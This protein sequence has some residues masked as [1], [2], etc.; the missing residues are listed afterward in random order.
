[1]TQG[2]YH[3]S[4]ASLSSAWETPVFPH[5]Y[6]EK[7]ADAVFA[8]RHTIVRAPTGAGKTLSVLAPFL[9]GRGKNC[10]QKL[11][12]VLPLRTLVEAIF[13]ESCK[14]AQ[15][16]GLSVA[17]Q[18]GER[19]DAEF[20][21]D[22]DI[23][24]TTFDQLLSGLLCEPYGLPRKLWNINAAAI[25]G[26]LIAFDEFH[27][28][29]PAEA[30]VTALFGVEMFKKMC[31]SVWMTATATAP[32]TQMIKARIG[33]S[34]IELS[35][36]EQI[37]LFEGR[38][39]SR[40]LRTHWDGTLTCDE[41]LSHGKSRVLAVVNT[42]GRAQQLAK[43]VRIATGNTPLLL[44]AR[45][46]SDDRQ[47]KQRLLKES[48]LTIATQVIEAGVDISCDVLLTEVAPVNALVQRAGRCA[49]FA[50]ESGIVHVYGTASP[51]PYAKSS[52]DTARSTVLD[53][54]QLDPHTCSRWVERAHAPED[55]D[56]LTGFG[57]LINKRRNLILGHVAGDGDLGAAAYIRKGAD[58]VR[59]FILKDATGA[60]PQELQ[61][62]QLYRNKVA[63]F[64]NSAHVYDGEN[65]IA[66]GDI[67]TAYAV[68]L[69][70]S[71]A[72]YTEELGLV[73]GS[74]GTIESRS[75]RSRC[76]PGYSSGLRMEPWATHTQNVMKESLLRLELE[77]LD[78]RFSDAVAWV[79]RLH[80]L[81]KLQHCWQEWACAVQAAR[82]VE[83]KAALAHTDYEWPADK[84]QPRPPKHATA[85]AILGWPYLD[86][87]S[88]EETTAILLAVVSHHGGTV[89]A[90][91]T[92]DE[93]HDF[94][95]SALEEVG[96]KLMKPGKEALL[97][98]NLGDNL[99]EDFARTWPLT[100]ILSRIL[101]LSD[102]KATSEYARG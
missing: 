84:G 63:R 83:V 94:A 4:F 36:R 25:A 68:A 58:T 74:A 15:P 42:V 52:I 6:Q 96:M 64:Q 38:G 100:A 92:P 87:L 71:V 1:M 90:Q 85:S 46:F 88:S 41:L 48:R 19:A 31:T 50:N 91:E 13:E 40:K 93:F 11:I 99:C 67:K 79:A 62:I 82:G 60:K 53:T 47:K 18:T 72:G 24:V 33:A 14:L 65:W 75:K 81:G 45:F 78:R 44:H 34:E 12:Y 73:L 101:R 29:G 9:L 69:P 39:I 20:F 80:D 26:K 30:F 51:L 7:V 70:P 28:M 10:I 102:Q 5:A 98:R 3:R 23:I 49:R 56:A 2:E 27:L 57:D 97:F 76:R 22:S 61:A 54:D 66:D 21:H 8:R 55:R 16:M 35:D 77:G 95:A 86:L 59:V 43:E 89:K 32:L 37:A 17:M